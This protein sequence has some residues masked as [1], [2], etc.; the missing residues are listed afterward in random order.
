MPDEIDGNKVDKFIVV[1]WVGESVKPM[2]RGMQ[3]LYNINFR[4]VDN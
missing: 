4:N 2:L 1:F 3:L